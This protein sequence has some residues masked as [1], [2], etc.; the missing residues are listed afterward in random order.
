MRSIR[1]GSWEWLRRWRVAPGATKAQ[2]QTL[3]ERSIEFPRINENLGGLHH[4]IVYAIDAGQ[5]SLATD[6]TNSV[7]KYNLKTGKSTEHVFDKGMASEFVHVPGKGGTGEDDGWLMGFV[8]D[9]ARNGSDL[10]ILD[11]QKIESK[12]VA[13]IQLPARVPQGFHGNWMP[14][15]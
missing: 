14:G 1:P 10:V 12:P 7:R 6:A 13:R 8:Y 3:D 5:G 11:A 4:D 9:Y 15:I 2:E